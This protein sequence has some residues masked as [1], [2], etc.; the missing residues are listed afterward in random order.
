MSRENLTPVQEAI[1]NEIWAKLK[2]HFDSVVLAIETETPDSTD[3]FRDGY[4]H[5]GAS[6]SLGL[7]VWMQKK[8]LDPDQTV[9][10]PKDDEE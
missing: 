3:K 9:R 8:L 2:E 1:L 7:A 6:V 4:W 10:K 5:G